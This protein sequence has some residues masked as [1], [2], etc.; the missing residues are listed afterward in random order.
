MYDNA[1]N[2]GSLADLWPPSSHGSILLTSQDSSWLYQEH[3]S[4][5]IL[6][7]SFSMQ[8]GKAM[9]TDILRKQGLP[10]SEQVAV[11]LIEE[12][13]GLPLA[14][15]HIASYI[16]ATDSEPMEF[17]ENYRRDRSSSLSVDQ[18][19]HNTPP[20]YGHTLATF[21]DFAFRHLQGPSMFL[22]SIISFLDP[23]SIPEELF[24]EALNAEQPDPFRNKIR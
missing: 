23:D 17:L 1:L 6:L 4:F 9:L 16:S 3:V 19:D 7:E 14:I 12:T 15:R 2:P 5:Q 21:L 11:A 24:T 13:G 18:W 8:D 20:W 22:L 10:V